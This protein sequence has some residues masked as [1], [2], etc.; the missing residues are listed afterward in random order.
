VGIET[1]DPGLPDLAVWLHPLI[2]FLEGFDAQAPRPGLSGFPAID[3]TRSLEH[4]QVP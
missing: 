2:R 3:E 1:G 4:L